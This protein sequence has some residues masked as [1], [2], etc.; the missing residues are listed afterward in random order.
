MLLFLILTRGFGILGVGKARSL[1]VVVSTALSDGVSRSR[2][3]AAELGLLVMIP[4]KVEG[5]V[6]IFESAPEIEYR[7]FVPSSVLQLKD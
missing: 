3:R 5:L 7:A 6:V 1:T 4:S 2:S